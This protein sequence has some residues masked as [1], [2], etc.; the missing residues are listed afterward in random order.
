MKTDIFV[1]LSEIERQRETA[2]EVRRRI[3]EGKKAFITTFGCQQNEADSERLMGLCLLMGYEKSESLEDADLIIFNTCA[4]REHAE[5]K[6]LSKTGALKKQK[7]RKRGT[8]TAVCGCM[9][10]QEGR[11]AQ[12]LKSYPYI[13]ILFGTD[14]QHRLP[15][16]VLEALNKRGVNV[17]VS[18]LTHNEFGV[19]AEGL[20][21]ER[22]S[23]YKAW[24]S[25][26]YGCDNFCSYCVVPQV[27]GRERSRRSAD[28]LSETE[29]LVKAGYKD[30]TLLGQNV[31][32]YEGDYSF[33]ELLRRVA[34]FEGDY[35]VRF[36]TSHPKDASKEL[37]KAMAE[38]ARIAPHFHLPMQSGDNRILKLMN[39]GYTR[40]EY[41]EKAAYI[42]ELTP[43]AALSSDIIC[44][45]P[46]ETEAE[47]ENTV[48]AV[49]R[50]GFDML[51]TFVYS[52]RPGTPAAK[53]EQLPHK[54]KTDRFARLSELENKRAAELNARFVGKRL[55]VLSEGA[56]GVES[57]ER[58]I[59]NAGRGTSS[60]CEGAVSP[61]EKRI[62]TGRTGHNKII[63]FTLPDGFD[64]KKAAAGNFLQVEVSAAQAYT[65][66]GAGVES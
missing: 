63:S 14:R 4:I 21:T 60:S 9:A 6:A 32:S 57:R 3:G 16:M 31:N 29:E 55:R 15:E 30:I 25:V 20:P 41:M 44:G 27:R 50:V 52:P 59:E 53:M 43:D 46:T 54:V 35:W 7:E 13:D 42:R 38:N 39:R 58:E 61:A 12:I 8:I 11:R 33:P 19:I 22:E 18:G 34:S 37:S 2:L 64:R 66:R 26:M 47:F 24:V 28:I 40:E 17:Y 48:D 56:L 1:S 45:F 23:V 36:M 5:L 51:F 62:Y 65:L 10:E 49:D